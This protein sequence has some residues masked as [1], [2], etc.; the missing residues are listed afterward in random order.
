MIRI[1]AGFLLMIKDEYRLEILEL[2]LEILYMEHCDPEENTEEER[3]RLRIALRVIPT[4]PETLHQVLCQV[5]DLVEDTCFTKQSRCNSDLLAK[6]LRPADEGTPASYGWDC[7][8]R[9]EQQLWCS[10]D[11]S[12]CSD[13]FSGGSCDLEAA[14]ER[15]ISQ[16]LR[17]SRHLRN[18][19]AHRDYQCEG[20]LLAEILANVQT[21]VAVLG[22]PT[23]AEKI[24]GL[25]T[26]GFMV[27]IYAKQEAQRVSDLCIQEEQVQDWQCEHHDQ[28]CAQEQD[29]Q[30]E[31]Q[32]EQQ[33]EP[34]WQPR[35]VDRWRLLRVVSRLLKVRTKAA[36][37]RATRKLRF[38]LKSRRGRLRLSQSSSTTLSIDSTDTEW[39]DCH[40]GIV[41]D[42]GTIRPKVDYAALNPA[43][44][45]WLMKAAQMRK[46]ESHG[47]LVR[48]ITSQRVEGIMMLGD[49]LGLPPKLTV[50]LVFEFG[51]EAVMALAQRWIAETTRTLVRF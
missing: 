9:V 46:R 37:A 21:L 29:W 23:A 22:N 14:S 44:F 47:G 2:A 5:Q 39:V 38:L 41:T 42:I 36:R 27:S 8:E 49:H 31:G 45:E 33:H 19:A 43:P 26:K 40:L 4:E 51:E 35:A 48:H 17:S 3:E 50:Y 1:A 34:R 32:Q 10:V 13:P 25:R 15:T 24:E 12:W 20:S 16:L 28:Q 11:L 6:L 30:W 7:P 18:C